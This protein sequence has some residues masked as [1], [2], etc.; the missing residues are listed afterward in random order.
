MEINLLNGALAAILVLLALW[1]VTR[2]GG[3]I[4]AVV[5]VVAIA[6]LLATPLV[7]DALQ[8]WLEDETPRV[9][10]ESLPKADAIVVLGGTLAPPAAPGESANLSAAA[11]RLVHAARLYA[12]GRDGVVSRSRSESGYA[13]AYAWTLHA[14]AKGVESLR[15]LFALERGPFARERQRV[16]LRIATVAGEGDSA[17][18]HAR[19][20]LDRFAHDFRDVLSA[21][22]NGD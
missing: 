21:L 8:S 2:R 1:L 13:V 11:D 16:F 19:H 17:A 15:S 18:R 4:V 5:V 12:L 10:A 9:P 14:D 20:W 22:E 7:S 6:W 3:F